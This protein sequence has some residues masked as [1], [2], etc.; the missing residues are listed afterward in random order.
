HKVPAAPYRGAGRPQAVFVIERL[1]DIAAHELGL[2]PA[3]LRRRNLIPAAAMPY[4]RD[5]PYR[6]GA[7]MLHDS[8]DYPALLEAALR[9]SGYAAFRARQA[10]ARRA[11]RLLGIGV[12]AYNEATGVGPHEGAHVA[13]EASGAV[14]VT[15]G[16]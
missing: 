13:V 11:G 5:I 6:D 15:V 3:E 14:R 1:L 16:A 4:R 12:A 2:D 8:G 7:P 9:E 10:E